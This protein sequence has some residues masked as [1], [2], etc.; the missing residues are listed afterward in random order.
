MLASKEDLLFVALDT[1]VRSCDN[2]V[3]VYL[4]PGSVTH[5]TAWLQRIDDAT[6][7][8]I[9][10]APRLQS[11]LKGKHWVSTRREVFGVD[12][13]QVDD[14]R[15]AL[16]LWTQTPLDVGYRPWWQRVYE[17][18]ASGRMA[19]VVRVHHALLD[20]Q[21]CKWLVESILL[22]SFEQRSNVDRYSQPLEIESFHG[23]KARNPFRGGEVVAP[24][25][26]GDT[27][28]GLKQMEV[29]SM[30]MTPLAQQRASASPA[31]AYEILLAGILRGITSSG[32][33]P[34]QALGICLPISIRRKGHFGWGNGASQIMLHDQ[35][36][37]DI[38][39][40][41]RHMHRQIRWHRQNGSWHYPSLPIRF[42]PLWLF[43][44]LIRFSTRMKKAD[45]GSLIVSGMEGGDWVN[46]LPF[47]QDVQVIMALT[48][49]HSLALCPIFL[50]DRINLC[51]T[52]NDGVFSKEDIRK[53]LHCI[54]R[55]VDPDATDTPLGGKG[56]TTIL[57]GIR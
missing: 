57:N 18:A 36:E 13:Q 52:Y 29:A 25:N 14:I 33:S 4:K 3:I 38:A 10:K 48:H 15:H 35:H 56:S 16:S 41:A 27:I 30:L 9:A 24:L 17:E 39:S 11:A 26:S 7:Q 50:Q 37:G 53:L 2:T 45:R 31:G 19:Y 5:V 22:E 49:N 40:L 34:Q 1:P 12:H 42:I 32:L 28:S 55:S 43:K 44:A 23:K 20:G 6:R 46:G 8:V 54:I 21:G 47:M 51:M